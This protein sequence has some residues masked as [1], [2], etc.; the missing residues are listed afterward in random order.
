MMRRVSLTLTHKLRVFQPVQ[1]PIND[2]HFWLSIAG[3][4]DEEEKNG[5]EKEADEHPVK[6]PAEEEVG[7][8]FQSTHG[9]KPWR[10]QHV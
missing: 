4:A 3:E 1:K 6:R 2:T 7:S 9:H 10:S 8:S 5:A